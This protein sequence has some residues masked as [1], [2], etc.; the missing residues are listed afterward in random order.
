MT[1][2]EFDVSP[3]SFVIRH[4]SFVIRHSSDC[5]IVAPPSPVTTH[6]TLRPS[7]LRVW[8]QLFRAP[9]LFTV[10]G[11]PLAGF[12][13]ANGSDIDRTLVFAIVASLC[14][15]AAGLLMNDLA[16]EAE[17][18]RERPS[19]P[20]PSRAVGRRSV[21]VVMTLLCVAGFGALAACRQ[22]AVLA[23]GG[24]LLGAIALYNWVTKSWP[25]VGAINMGLCRSLSLMLGGFVGPRADGQTAQIAAVGFGLYIAA[26]TNLARHETRDRAPVLARLLPIIV[27]ALTAAYG[28]VNAGYAPDKTPAIMLYA[29]VVAEVLCLAV[30]MF[31]KPVPLPPFIGAHIRALL[32][33]QAAT[34]Y[35]AEP[36]EFGIWAAGA[37]LCFWPVSR[38]VGRWFYAS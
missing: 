32:L 34:C 10:P 14:F 3:S 22:P 35:I 18:L 31:L 8:L 20:L 7:P 37:L 23:A 21:W 13:L 38:T 9:N 19:R 5:L 15:Y 25:V 36:T 16:D 4:S 28:I 17:D 29:L 27:L 30:E 12:L 11:D 33:L 26:V 6:P 24:A 2:D 1:N